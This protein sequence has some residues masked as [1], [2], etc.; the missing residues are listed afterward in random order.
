[1]L[2]H[3]VTDTD[4]LLAGLLHDVGKADERTRVHLSHRVALVVGRRF[5]PDWLDRACARPGAG[6]LRR[7]LYLAKH[8]AALGAERAAAAGASARCCALIAAHD[9]SD[10]S[11][12]PQLRLLRSAD[13]HA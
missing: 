1:M 11:S 4:L 5:I 3:G 7:G 12:D 10:P 6:G 2:A 13:E 9:S 8:H